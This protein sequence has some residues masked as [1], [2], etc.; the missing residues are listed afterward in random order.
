MKTLATAPPASK[1]PEEF[2]A[3]T[4]TYNFPKVFLILNCV[5]TYRLG[6]AGFIL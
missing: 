1:T 4:V 2:A 6:L 5:D 3:S